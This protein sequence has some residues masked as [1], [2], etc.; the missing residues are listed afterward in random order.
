MTDEKPECSVSSNIMSMLDRK[1]PLGEQE[2]SAIESLT[3]LS[4]PD[5]VSLLSGLP[6]FQRPN[7]LLVG[8]IC[9][10][11]SISTFLAVFVFSSKFILL[12][13]FKKSI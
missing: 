3:S 1:R 9:S 5:A 11:T 4:N 10:K 7:P 6:D 8:Q 2:Q 13:N 12:V